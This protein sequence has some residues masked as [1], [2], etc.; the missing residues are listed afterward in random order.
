MLSD[1]FE[2]S[3]D[4][5]QLVGQFSS[6]G[7]LG[8]SAEKWLTSE[9]L[10]SLSGSGDNSLKQPTKKAKTIKSTANL[11]LVIIP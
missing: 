7:S 11:S 2:A 3:V 1:E 5:N 4:H 9:F 10:T 6:I 8:P